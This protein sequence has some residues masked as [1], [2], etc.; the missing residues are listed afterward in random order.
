MLL[1]NKLNYMRKQIYLLI[2]L[3]CLTNMRN[4]LDLFEDAILYI[5]DSKLFTSIKRR[6]QNII[7]YFSYTTFT[8]S[9]L[10]KVLLLLFKNICSI[11]I[12]IK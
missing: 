9:I 6:Y 8:N 2:F 5:R 10:L 11:L 3:F 12:L 4:L 7:L 1:L